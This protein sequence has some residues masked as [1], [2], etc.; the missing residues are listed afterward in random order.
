MSDWNPRPMYASQPVVDPNDDRRIYMLNSYSYSDDGGE[1]LHDA[2]A[3][4]ARRRPLRLGQPERLASRRQAGRR[5]HRHQYDRGLKFLYV[6]SLP[7]SQYYRVAVD[8]AHPYNVYGGLQDNGCWVGPSASWT[9]NGMLNEHW[10][11]L[12]GGDG[13]FAVPDPKNPSHR[14]LGVAVPRPAAQRHP[15]VA[16]AGHPS[17]RPDRRHRRPPQL[18]HVGQAR[19]Q[20]VLGNAMH[21][22]N[23]D[24]PV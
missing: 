15:H 5:R 19:R 16:G 18:G 8:N 7:L 13:F 1:D 21:P 23:W 4:A 6:T 22:A 3:D 20:Q 11:R 17:R 12:C 9:T 10:S 2:A 14:L 24:A